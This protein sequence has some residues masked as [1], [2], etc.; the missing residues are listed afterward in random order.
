M[1][2]SNYEVEKSDKI[3]LLFLSW[4]DIQAPK[5]G[6]AEVFTHEMLKRIDF[7]KYRVIHI[8]PS[9][10]NSKDV[11]ILDNITYIRVGNSISVIW[12]A[13]K[14][15]MKNKDKVNFV[16]DQCN[17]HRFFTK[18]WVEHKK[19]IFF[20]HQLT[21]EIWFLNAKF[22]INLIGYIT[23]TPFLRL[24]KNDYTMTVS[25]S[26]RQDLLKIGFKNDKVRILP[27]GIEF[28]HW[29]EEEFSQKEK[30]P[31]FVYVGRFVNY[32]GID[33]SILAFA[34]IKK[35][36]PEAKL[37][38]V[39]KKN[40][41]YIENNLKPIFQN[42]NITWGNREE[43]RDVT[44]FGFVSDEEKLKLMSMSHG[45]LFPSQREGWGLIVTEA[46]AVGTPSI[47]YNSPG[48]IDA[49]DN[50]KAGYLC[51]ENTPDNL[52]KLMKRVI[53]RKDEYEEY[54]EN[55]YRYSLKFHWDKTAKSFDDFINEVIKDR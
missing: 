22:P 44:L 47:V 8:S 16:V 20:I 7:E 27:E 32:K 40:D 17:T 13:R 48:I 26:T 29:K 36:Y 21:R 19:R 38:I 24:S 50:G 45:L 10:Q 53:E 14:F 34:K 39:G 9:F 31:T 37:Y 23:E 46:A 15:Y 2:I 30:V 49:V 54:R 42:E 55:A 4:R 28:E 1:E 11:E 6:G 18:F 5:K 25:E 41:K 51:D 52:Y 3:T 12:E 43:N 35:E 33:A